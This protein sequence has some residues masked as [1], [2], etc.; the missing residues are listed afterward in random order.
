MSLMTILFS[1]IFGAL[2]AWAC[3]TIAG[4]KGRDT[5]L[6]GFIGFFGGLIALI[7]LLC[8]SDESA[9][10]PLNMPENP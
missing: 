9:N 4:K 10:K 3:Y 5:T 2:F 6:W 8:L 7:V 1:L